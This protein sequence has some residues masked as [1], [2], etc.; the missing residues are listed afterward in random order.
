M[1][2]AEPPKS[3]AD[4]EFAIAGIPVRI[5][6]LFWLFTIMPMFSDRAFDS[7]RAAC[8]L[9]VVL[10]S[11]L[12]HELGHAL[13]ARY[14]GAKPWITLYAFGGLA[15][16]LPQ[17]LTRRF[18]PTLR[19]ILISIA[20]PAAGFLF[21]AIVLA[22]LQLAGFR[23]SIHGLSI[24]LDERLANI[25]PYLLFFLVQLIFVNIVWG[26]LNLLP[27]YPLDGGQ[28][29]QAILIRMMGVNGLI[30]SVLSG[31]LLGGLIAVY[32]AFSLQN[33]FLAILFGYL[34]FQNY[35]LYESLRHRRW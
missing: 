6:P 13:T 32:G 8:W 15:S 7:L 21:A 33:S 20:G 22:I 25:N 30:Q 31:V 2:L 3:G 11:V 23:V 14:F 5:H 29:L 1:I 27:V 35:Q 34:A 17:D 10:I 26:L 16:Y 28:I 24:D 9:S 4:V 18:D 19:S 12:I